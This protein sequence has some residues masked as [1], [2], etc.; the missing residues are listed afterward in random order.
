MVGVAGACCSACFVYLLKSRCKTI[1][2]WGVV[3]ERDVVPVD[4]P[5]EA[6]TLAPN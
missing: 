4:V 6:I 5:V 1:K 3:C 2:C